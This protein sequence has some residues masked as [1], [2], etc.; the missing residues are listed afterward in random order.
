MDMIKRPDAA[1][2][3]N[4]GRYYLH[5]GYNELFA[6]GQ[7][8]WCGAEYTPSDEIEVAKDD[9]VQFVDNVGQ[10][11]IN[12]KKETEK[13]K[14]GTKQIVSIVKYLSDLAKRKNIEPKSLWLNPLPSNLDYDELA[15]NTA[16]IWMVL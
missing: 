14:T 7:S 2:L 11:I 12:V 4:T 5:V 13:V 3:K 9:S 1:E 15:M 10:V 8:A 6:Q 16:K